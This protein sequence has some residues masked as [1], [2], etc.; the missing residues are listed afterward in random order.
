[1][2]AYLV[3]LLPSSSYSFSPLPTNEKIIFWDVQGYRGHQNEF[4]VKEMAFLSLDQTL[5]FHTI[6]KPPFSKIFFIFN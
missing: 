2:D 5:K 1:M 4:A 6:Y 3:E